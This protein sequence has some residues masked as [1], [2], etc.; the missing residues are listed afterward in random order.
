MIHNELFQAQQLLE[1]SEV[2]TC[3]KRQDVIDATNKV[4]RA[5]LRAIEYEPNKQKELFKI[6]SLVP[7]LPHFD[8]HM[9][10]IIS[11]YI[12]LG[13]K[14]VAQRLSDV[15]FPDPNSFHAKYVA[16]ELFGREE[17]LM[18]CFHYQKNVTVQNLQNVFN[19]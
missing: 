2:L 10:D 17:K 16:L 1:L 7:N 6:R 19:N 18:K 3:L 13:K 14:S 4:W 5:R 15:F 11:Y 12:W 9:L 8:A